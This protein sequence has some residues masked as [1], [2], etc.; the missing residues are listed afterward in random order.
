MTRTFLNY[1]DFS[2]LV[3]SSLFVKW[4]LYNT[5]K[6]M[7]HSYKSKLSVFGCLCFHLMWLHIYLLPSAVIFTL[8]EHK[9]KLLKKHKQNKSREERRGKMKKLEHF[10]ICFYTEC[11]KLVVMKYVILYLSLYLILFISHISQLLYIKRIS[12]DLSIFGNYL[13]LHSLECKVTL[14]IDCPVSKAG[15]KLRKSSEYA[16]SLKVVLTHQ[17]HDYMLSVLNCQINL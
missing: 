7:V 4:G 16:G 11:S 8:S 1:L 10:C 15:E 2:S 3:F 17:K 5:Q 13:S 14:R 12:C 9:L 6:W